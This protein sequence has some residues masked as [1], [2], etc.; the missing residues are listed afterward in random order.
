MAAGPGQVV[1]IANGEIAFFD[2]DGT[3]TF[4][5]EIEDSFGFWGSLGTTNFVFDPE[6]I[7][8]PHTDR[9]MAMANERSSSGPGNSYYLL[10]I[11]DDSDPNGL[12]HKYRINATPTASG[13]KDID[14]PN[15]A[16]DDEVIYLTADFFN[17]DRLH[18]MMVDKASVIDGGTPVF[19]RWRSPGTRPRACR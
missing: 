9:F 6:V 1:V 8:D 14:S 7:Y 3:N 4:R 11:S 17:P 19:T 5:D 2:K 15:I 16:V 13:G 12:W 18:V 10:A